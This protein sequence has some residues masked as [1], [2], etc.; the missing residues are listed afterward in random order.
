MQRYV[1]ETSPL[2]DRWLLSY[3]DLLTLLLA[4]FVVMYSVSVV[5]QKKL[6]EIASSIEAEMI[7]AI[8]DEIVGAQKAV[9]QTIVDPVKVDKSKVVG[10][11]DINISNVGFKKLNNDWVEFTLE[12]EFL[13]ASGEA[14]LR[15]DVNDTLNNLLLVLNNTQGDIRVEG[16]TDDKAISTL[17]F[18][19][20]WELSAARAAAVVRYFEA[21]GVNPNRLSATGLSSSM[22]VSKNSSNEGRKENRR[23]VLKIRALEGDFEKLGALNY[24]SE[25]LEDLED[26]GQDDVNLDSIDHEL[27]MQILNKID[28]DAIQASP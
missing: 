15:L 24:E 14:D 19:S 1:E 28:A 10:P 6:Q 16:H 9:D 4:F 2:R 12:S 8:S 17:R 27:L 26:L 5:D 25:A 20:N 11:L 21:R 7:G 22:P 18:P 23:V 3:A 13:F